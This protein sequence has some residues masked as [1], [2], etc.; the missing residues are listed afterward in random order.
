MGATEDGASSSGGTCNALVL[1]DAP[2]PTP[3]PSTCNTEEQDLIDLLSI[4]LTTS[5]TS[6][7]TTQPINS[8]PME[9]NFEVFSLFIIYAAT[10]VH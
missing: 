5:S 2:V 3:T 9:T 7:E 1:I 4:V 10:I 8:A 6:S